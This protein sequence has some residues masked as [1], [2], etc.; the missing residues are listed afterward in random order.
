LP[1][2]VVEGNR[3]KKSV[4][5]FGAPVEIQTGHR[6]NESQKFYGLSLF[7]ATSTGDIK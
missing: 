6:L 5:I 7:A 2:A 1:A 3:Y 4:R